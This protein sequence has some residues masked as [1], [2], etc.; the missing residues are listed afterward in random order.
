MASNPH[1]DNFIQEHTY[2]ILM[3]ILKPKPDWAS[4]FIEKYYAIKKLSENE[5]EFFKAYPHLKAQL[6]HG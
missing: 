6:K 3:D 2:N 4:K 1:L 5:E